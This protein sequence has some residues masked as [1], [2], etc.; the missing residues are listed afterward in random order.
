MS[1]TAKGIHMLKS[2]EELITDV[3]NKFLTGENVISAESIKY[4]P[5]FYMHVTFS[6]CKPW[7]FPQQLQQLSI[8]NAIHWIS[9]LAISACHL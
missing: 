5:F 9:R 6:D 1:Q 2:L 4:D 7:L 3:I 8:S